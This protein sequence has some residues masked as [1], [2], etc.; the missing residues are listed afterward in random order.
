MAKIPVADSDVVY[1]NVGGTVLATK[2]STL[3]Q[4]CTV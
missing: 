4:V 3:T 1:L 2:W